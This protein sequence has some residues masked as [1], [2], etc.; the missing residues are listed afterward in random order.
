MKGNQ[1]RQLLSILIIV[2]IAVI[3]AV[4][5]LSSHDHHDHSTDAHDHGHGAHQDDHE[6]MERGPHRGRLLK[7]DDFALEI[8]IFETGVP[9]E[10]R[11]YAYNNNAPLRPQDVDLLI[12]LDRLGDKQDKIQFKAEQDYLRGDSI[13]YEPHSFFVTVQA[14]YQSK[15]YTWKYENYEGRTM[16]PEKMAT[17]M[18]IKTD[19]IG[20]KQLTQ[21][22]TLTG[23][24]H[25]DPNRLSRVKPRFPGIVQTIH[26]ELGS[27]VKQGSTLAT[28]Q[29]NESLQSYRVKAPISGMIIKRDLQIGEATGENPLFIIA[30]LSVMWAELDIFI[31]D[32]S[33]INP[34]QSVAIETIDGH[35]LTTSKI[36]WISPLTAH[37]SQSVRA[38]IIIDNKDNKVRPGQ[39][40]RGHVTVAQTPVAMAVPKSA[41]QRFRDFQVVFARVG[42]TY[43]VRMLQLGRSNKD[44]IEVLGGIEPGT[45]YVTDNSY[46]IKADIE[47]SGATHDH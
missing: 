3:A 24:I 10:F 15:T 29:S 17:A 16:I 22:K 32:L 40:V 45:T 7:Q 4:W 6:E 2:L 37:A 5:Q 14:T 39:F 11:I 41:L 31:G 44:W 34:G 33:L 43:E 26:Y 36:D 30:D 35:Y 13:I 42:D 20:P 28:I 21:T 27:Y 12:T 38:R 19:Q 25:S 8:T 1:R 18:G 9:P 23:R 46:L 47:K